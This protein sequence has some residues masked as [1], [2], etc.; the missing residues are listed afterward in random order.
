M[1]DYNSI[2]ADYSQKQ[3]EKL[4]D[5]K[6][7]KEARA[8]QLKHNINLFGYLLK[9]YD[10]HVKDL[11]YEEYSKGMGFIDSYY[12]NIYEMASLLPQTFLDYI[13]N[14]L[15]AYTKMIKVLGD[16]I[17]KGKLEK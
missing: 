14:K 8:L 3:R 9:K 2:L 1:R 10:E 16:K 4:E 5:A 6:D 12:K 13:R 17:D 11:D 15:N 7:S